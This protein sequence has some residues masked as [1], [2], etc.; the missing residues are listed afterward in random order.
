MTSLETA[1]ASTT[2]SLFGFAPG[3]VYNA[4][5]VTDRAVGSYPT[6]SPLPMNQD[7]PLAV[8]FLLHFP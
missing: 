7:D 2:P 1:G 8:C 4:T 5:L 3:G 6:F